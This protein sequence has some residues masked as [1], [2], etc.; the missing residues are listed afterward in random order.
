[1]GVSTVRDGDQNIA[2]TGDINVA[3]TSEQNG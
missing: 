1:M 3:G 2:R